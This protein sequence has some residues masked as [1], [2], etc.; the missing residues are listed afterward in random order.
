MS[1]PIEIA[2]IVGILLTMKPHSKPP[3]QISD[4]TLFFVIF[5]NAFW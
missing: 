3:L 2:C 5:L 1:G 4:I